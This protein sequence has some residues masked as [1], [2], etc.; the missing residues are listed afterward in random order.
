MSYTHLITE[1]NERFI[2]T[3]TLNRPDRH[4]SLVPAMLRDFGDALT[5][6]EEDPGARVLVLRAAGRSFSTGGDMQGFFSTAAKL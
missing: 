6:C 3:I 4:N 5:A 1:V 2:G